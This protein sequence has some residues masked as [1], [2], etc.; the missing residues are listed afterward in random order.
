MNSAVTRRKRDLHPGPWVIAY[1]ARYLQRWNPFLAR[2]WRS[3]S[4]HMEDIAFLVL[5]AK[6]FHAALCISWLSFSALSIY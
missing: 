2:Q 1:P 5:G 4:V 6:C 3:Y